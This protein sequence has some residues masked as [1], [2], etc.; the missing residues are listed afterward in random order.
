[1]SEKSSSQ[2]NRLIQEQGIE[3]V[4]P[5]SQ[6]PLNS[7]EKDEP[8]D[9]SRY[10]D[11]TLYR[12]GGICSIL[13]AWDSQENRPVALKR[14][15]KFGREKD[16]S[17]KRRVQ[18]EFGILQDVAHDNI[19][20]VYDLQSE[21]NSIVL[22]FLEGETLRLC[23]S[24]KKST[25]EAPS[26]QWIHKIFSSL[27]DAVGHVHEK[28]Y[29]H[30]DIKPENI[31]I[32]NEGKVK[33]LD[34]GMA[35]RLNEP[36]EEEAEAG[37][38]FYT[39]PEYKHREVQQTQG[40]RCRTSA[41]VYSL[42]AILFELFTYD[43][44][45]GQLG[46]MEHFYLEKNWKLL[47]KAEDLDVIIATAMASIR[48][49]RQTVT[50]LKYKWNLFFRRAVQ[51]SQQ[52]PTSIPNQQARH[53]YIFLS[54]LL[55]VGLS[56]QLFYFS[57]QMP[58]KSIE[59]PSKRRSSKQP[60]APSS[61]HKRLSQHRSIRPKPLENRTHSQK[62]NSMEPPSIKSLKIKEKKDLREKTKVRRK[63][64]K[65]FKKRLFKRHQ[66]TTDKKIK[67]ALPRIDR[68]VSL[69]HQAFLDVSIH[70]PC[71]LYLGKKNLGIAFGKMLSFDPKKYR[72]RCEARSHYFSHHFSL[73]LQAGKTARYNRHFKKG[74]LFVLSYPWAE[75]WL[76]GF[77]KIGAS[78]QPIEFYEGK[79]KIVLF[80]EGNPEHR[81]ELDIHILPGKTTR[82]KVLW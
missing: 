24:R 71:T 48:E 68:K 51:L 5:P 44:A 31:M 73:Q 7:I 18:K 23:L 56:V 47:P 8:L 29:V 39:A 19:V 27:L 49:E 41:D 21:E 78:Q 66:Q 62:T 65:R 14:F 17:L 64:S 16:S 67:I 82:P 75:V 77:N 30:L 43:I 76:P 60:I 45:K 35:H 42:G 34:F 32:T 61:S 58:K 1:M 36:L 22:E 11:M 53:L 46:K 9:S 25:Q 38:E 63:K 12:E 55:I 37:T 20:A 74:K 4:P 3:T 59:T 57:I 28:G 15:K 54:A 72:F 40:L 81:K 26:L 13:K 70:P 10:R 2:K 52:T 79:Y 50:Q 33:L 6:T 80:K 69:V